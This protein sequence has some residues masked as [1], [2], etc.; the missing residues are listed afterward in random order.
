[1]YSYICLSCICLLLLS[2]QTVV[3]SSPDYGDLSGVTTT[4]DGLMFEH[5]D[6]C[7]NDSDEISQLCVPQDRLED[8]DLFP[9]FADDLILFRFSEQD[10][11]FGE[12]ELEKNPKK[13]FRDTEMKPFFAKDSSS[14]DDDVGEVSFSPP[15]EYSTQHKI[16]DDRNALRANLSKK[17]RSKRPNRLDSLQT[18]SRNNFT[19]RRRCSHCEAENTPQWRMGP[20]GPKT[21]CNACGVRYKSGRLVPAASPTFDRMKH[22]NYHRRIMQKKITFRRRK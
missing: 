16:N 9:D 10:Y 3:D 21:L 4:S 22:S 19:K 6:F 5:H 1:M 2:F 17:P 7:S 15:D 11:N 8:L 14:S 18:K 13:D 12:I 20:E